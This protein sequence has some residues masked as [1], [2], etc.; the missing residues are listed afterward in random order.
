MSLY[1]LVSKKLDKD[2]AAQIIAEE[3][4]RILDACRPAHLLLF[5]SAARNELRESSD[6]DFIAIFQNCKQIT[7]AKESYY[8]TLSPNRIAVD[9][10]FFTEQEFWE[11]SKRGGVCFV[12]VNE[13]RFI[14][15]NGIKGALNGS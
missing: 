14:F 3:S 11:R 1:K 4:G 15:S 5:G 8:R 9:L 7:E 13:G 12:A 2:R 10:L 6:L